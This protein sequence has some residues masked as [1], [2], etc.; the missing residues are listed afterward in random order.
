MDEVEFSHVEM[1]DVLVGQTVVSGSAGNQLLV[2]YVTGDAICCFQLSHQ[3]VEI[4]N[5]FWIFIF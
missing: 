2:E 5:S 1:P 4:L 3:L